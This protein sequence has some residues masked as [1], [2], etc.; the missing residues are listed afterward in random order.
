MTRNTNSLTYL[1]K[2]RLLRSLDGVMLFVG[3]IAGESTYR[4][5]FVVRRRKG[6]GNTNP[7]A[8]AASWWTT[9]SKVVGCSTGISAGLEPRKILSVKVAAFLYRS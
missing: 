4:I 9:N 3:S 5:T 8:A 6:S 7:S 2:M 1:R